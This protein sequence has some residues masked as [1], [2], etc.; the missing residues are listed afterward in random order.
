[1]RTVLA[2]GI[3]I[4]T[5]AVTMAGLA[6]CGAPQQIAVDHAWVRL[7]AV[8]ANPAAAY[9]TL[10]GG[11]TDATLI[12]VST[13]G[14]AKAEM[15]ET[16]KAGQSMT[17]MEPVETVQLPAHADVSFKP[18]GRH[19]MLFGVKPGIK[20]GGTMTLSFAFADGHRVEQAADVI[21]AGAAA[22]E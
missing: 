9:F 11:A 13:D 10:H 5:L 20:P 12:G 7:S 2:R 6:S 21:A 18:G 22:P 15:H 3:G 16:M 17:R 19:V 4:A 14:A 1:M 8:E